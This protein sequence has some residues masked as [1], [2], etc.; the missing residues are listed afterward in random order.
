MEIKKKAVLLHPQSGKPVVL[1]LE[2]FGRDKAQKDRYLSNEFCFLS[3]LIL[4]KVKRERMFFKSL[5]Y[6]SKNNSK[7]SLQKF[8]SYLK[9]ALSLHSLL[10]RKFP[11]ARRK[12][13]RNISS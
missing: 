10:K 11:R 9:F 5:K 13:F 6:L 1:V 7:K 3:I 4:T 2:G 8:G 12:K